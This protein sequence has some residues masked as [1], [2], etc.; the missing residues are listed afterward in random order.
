MGPYLDIGSSNRQLRSHEVVG[1]AL[2]DMTG[3]DQVTEGRPRE[4]TGRSWPPTVMEGGLRR[5][6]SC[7]HLQLGLSASRTGSK[8][9]LLSKPPGLWR[10]L[11][12]PLE[13]TERPGGICHCISMQPGPGERDLEP[14]P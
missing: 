5:N 7:P 10:F 8:S 14:Q 2:S 6:R 11:S 3:V 4:D 1:G 12:Q 13:Q 9:I